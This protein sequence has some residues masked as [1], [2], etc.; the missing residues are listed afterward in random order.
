MKYYKL[1]D[2]GRF[3]GVGTS[4]DFRKYQLKHNILLVSDEDSAQYIQIDEK[5]Y[6]DDWLAPVT[7][8]ALEYYIV[9]IIEIEKEEYDILHDA[10]ET[11]REIEV[12]E[13][14]QDNRE[15]LPQTDP[16]EEV[17]IEYVKAVKIAEMSAACNMIITEGFDVV[18]SDGESHHFSLTIQDQLNLIT[19]SSM[20]AA[21]ETVIPYHADGEL[22]KGYSVDDINAITESATAFKTYHVTYYNSLKAYIESIDDICGVNSI[23]YGVDIPEEYQ[24]DVL[25]MLILQKFLG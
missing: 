25:K 17:T 19:L 15:E 2:G 21:G 12:T 13:P 23:T 20:V 22:C 3:I 8:A 24:S 11:G 9:R 18:L 7:T 1:I 6:R 4:F 16:N 14:E 10:V 5:L